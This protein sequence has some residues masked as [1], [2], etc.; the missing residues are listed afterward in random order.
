M[1]KD[2]FWFK[3][4]SNSRTD[5]KMVK[6]RRKSGLEGV[7]LFWCVVE[8]LRESE[9]YELELG[10]SDDIIYDLRT[11]E[12]VFESLFECELLA[13][14]ERVFYSESLKDRMT[15]MDK[16]RE[17]RRLAGSKGGKAKAN[18]KKIVANA[19]AVPK[20]NLSKA[21]ANPSDKNRVEENRVEENIK[22]LTPKKASE[23]SEEFNNFWSYYKKGNKKK[24][25]DKWKKLTPSQIE[26]IR[27]KCKAYVES[28]DREGM[29]FRKSGEVYL[30]PSNEHWNDE[31]VR[32]KENYKVAEPTKQ[33]TGVF[34]R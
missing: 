3:H 10:C 14:D 5:V 28:T 22:T 18:A 32:G 24:S 12:S 4:D 33:R 13:R 30:N 31:I 7:G 8:M 17:K 20:Q 11:T 23:Y 9:D 6:L 1:A 26:E 16:V 29:R 15:G 25:F 21:L 19:K 27:Q 34:A 2:A